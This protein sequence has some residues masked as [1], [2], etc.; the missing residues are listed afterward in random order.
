MADEER[1]TNA[2][3]DSEPQYNA[4]SFH[5]DRSGEFRRRV[6]RMITE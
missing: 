2:S 5:T 1:E 3:D 6:W 4:E